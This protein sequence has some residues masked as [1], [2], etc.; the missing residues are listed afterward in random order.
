MMEPTTIH[1]ALYFWARWALA[2]ALLNTCA[3]FARLARRVAPR[4]V[5]VKEPS[6]G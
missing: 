6:C 4:P 1:G 2:T 5:P 3:G